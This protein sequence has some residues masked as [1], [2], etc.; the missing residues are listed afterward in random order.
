MNLAAFGGNYRAYNN[1]SIG[2]ATNL[3]SNTG[4]TGY[5]V[6]SRV[7]DSESYIYKN[8]V[9]DASGT[10]ATNGHTPYPIYI[11]AL[12]TDGVF[13]AITCSAKSYGFISIGDGLTPAEIITLS[14]IVNTWSTS[15][16]RN[17]Y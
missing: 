12:N 17:T 8:G 7:N 6:S 2:L 3:T 4:T 14:N 1:N 10:T 16:G 15:I 11:G 9:F 5:Y 13:D